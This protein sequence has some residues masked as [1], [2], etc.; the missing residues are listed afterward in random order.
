MCEEEQNYI[1]NA[2][3]KCAARGTILSKTTLCLEYD[4]VRLC[5]GD[6]TWKSQKYKISLESTEKKLKSTQRIISN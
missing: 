4:M 1:L 2:R 3:N 5:P 6:S